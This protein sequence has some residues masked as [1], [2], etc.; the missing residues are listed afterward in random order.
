MLANLS[1]PLHILTALF[2]FPFNG[3]SFGPRDSLDRQIFPLLLSV[4]RM[5]AL[6]EG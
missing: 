2:I 3:A 6:R 5:E 4:L 1:I